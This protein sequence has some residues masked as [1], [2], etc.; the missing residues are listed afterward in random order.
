M[1][2]AL[3]AAGIRA[4]NPLNPLH[5][6]ALR[7]AMPPYAMWMLKQK[8]TPGKAP[9]L[10]EMPSKLKEHAEWACQQ[11]NKAPLEVSGTMRRHQLKLADR[12]CR[13]AELSGRLQ[14]LIVMLATSLHAARSKD[15]VIH[16]AADVLCQDLTRDL[17]GK[18]PSDRYFRTVTKLG[19]TIVDG[20]FKSIAGIDDIEILMSYAS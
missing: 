14:K 9:S 16:A 12:Q 20:G 2:K 5:L 13:M 3:Q 15:E 8:L 11:L 7:K 19:E 17:T 18:R 1:G 4:M 10:P 6:W